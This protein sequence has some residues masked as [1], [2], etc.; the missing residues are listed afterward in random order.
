ML[1]VSCGHTKLAFTVGGKETI[2]DAPGQIVWIVWLLIM[3][4]VV[5]KKFQKLANNQR[6]LTDSD[7]Q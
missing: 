5:M 2:R 6:T 1:M 3:M 7:G 4:W